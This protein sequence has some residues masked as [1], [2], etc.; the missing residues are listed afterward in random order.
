MVIEFVVDQDKRFQK[1]VQ[2]AL[3]QVS[4]LTIPFNLITKSWFKGNKSIFSLSGKGKYEDLSPKYKARKASVLGSAYPILRGMTGRLESSITD[5]TSRDSIAVILNKRSL[6][7]GTSTPYGPYLQ[8]GTNK[9]PA[10]PFIL[11]GAEQVSPSE[12]NRRKEAWINIIGDYVKQ[13]AERMA[14][15]S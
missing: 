4:D 8:M 3:K 2:D 13:V 7:L 10:R 9:M 11:L 6:V 1:S 12:I 14:R 15:R 5:P